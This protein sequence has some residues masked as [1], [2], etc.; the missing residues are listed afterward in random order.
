MI[1][2][3]NKML[4]H[5]KQYSYYLLLFVWH[6]LCNILHRFFHNDSTTQLPNSATINHTT[7]VSSKAISNGVY[8][9]CS[10]LLLKDKRMG[11]VSLKDTGTM[12]TLYLVIV[13]S[14]AFEYI[15]QTYIKT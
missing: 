2:R 1:V 13:S 15:C 6:A 4:L 5:N 12:V 11:R 7:S 14:V 10:V 9:C 8:R 3:Q